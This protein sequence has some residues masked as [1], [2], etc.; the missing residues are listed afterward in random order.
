MRSSLARSKLC[1]VRKSG[2]VVGDEAP[3][4]SSARMLSKNVAPEVQTP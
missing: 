3:D 4:L 1:N 2:V